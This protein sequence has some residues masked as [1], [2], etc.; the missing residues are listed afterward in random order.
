MQELEATDVA[1]VS[2][3]L[4]LVRTPVG[5]SLFGLSN[6]EPVDSDPFIVCDDPTPPALY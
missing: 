6:G 1:A 5:F 3:G 4:V 2:G